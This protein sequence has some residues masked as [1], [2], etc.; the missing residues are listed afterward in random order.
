[1]SLEVAVEVAAE[2]DEEE[3]AV[4]VVAGVVVVVTGLP[5]MTNWGV[6]LTTLVSWSSIISMA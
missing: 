4:E 6:K 5:L 3:T 1:M 2:V